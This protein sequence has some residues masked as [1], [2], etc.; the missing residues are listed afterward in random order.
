MKVKESINQNNKP[1]QM[2]KLLALLTV[3]I[4]TVIGVYGQAPGIFNYQGVARNSV[5]NVLVNK[6]ITLRLTIHDVAS[7]GAVVYQE[8]RAVT[9]NPFGLFNVQVGSAGATNVTGTIAG[10][11]WAVG[12]KYIQVEIDP[13]GGTTF[14][15]IG[16]AQIASVPYAWYAAQAGDLILPYN[17]TQADNGTLFKITNSGTNTGS[18]ALEGLTNSTA[19]NANA[20]IGTVSSTSPGG[21]SAGIR[22]INNGTGGLGIGVYGSQAGSGWG[23]YGTTPSG[24]GVYGNTNSGTGVYGFANTGTGVFGTSTT[25]NAGSFSNT[26]AA[27]N[28]STLLVTSNGT[29]WAGDFASTNATTRALRTA[30]GLQH[31]GIGEA[32]NR[33]LVSDA[34]GNATW[35]DAS[36]I[37]VVTGSG[38]LNFV[39]KW[40][41]TGT[42]LGNSQIFDNGTSVGIN[43]A[44]PNAAYR[45]E[46]NGIQRINLTNTQEGGELRFQEGTLFGAPNHW[47]IDNFESFAGGNKFR[48]WNDA[49]SM[50]FQMMPTG[51]VAVGNMVFSDQPQSTM[52]IEG[53]LAVGAT[54]SG[55]NA[56]PTNGM[57]VEGNVGIGTAV[58]TAKLHLV[59][60]NAAVQNSFVVSQSNATNTAVA[61]SISDVN[62]TST[63][64]GNGAIYS[65]RGTGSLANT[66]LYT[67][68]ATSITGVA[69]SIQGFGVQGTSESGYGVTGL[70]TTGIGVHGINLNTGNAARFE[71]AINA[72]NASPVVLVNDVS[73]VASSFGVHSTIAS[74]APGGFSAALRG[75][76]NGTGG[77]GIGVW[78]SQNGLGWGVYGTAAGA[79]LGVVGVAGTNGTGVYALANGPASSALHAINDVGFAG[80]F[81]ATGTVNNN[82]AL[83]VSDADI[84]SGA[85]VYRKAGIYAEL[86]PLATGV[87]RYASPAAIL[88]TSV[89]STTVALASG[90][91]VMGASSSGV[92][93]MGNTNGGVGLVGITWANGY[94]LQAY[95]NSSFNSFGSGGT[96][97]QVNSNSFVG[98]PQI[99]LNE[100][101]DDFARLT[102]RNTNALN[103][104]NNFWDIAG[105]T[106]NTRSFE[107]LNF[108]NNATGNLMS[109]TGTGSVGIGTTNPDATLFVNEGKSALTAGYGFGSTIAAKASVSAATGNNTIALNTYTN[110]ST[111]QNVSIYSELGTTGTFNYGVRAD[112]VN[113][114]VGGTSW[115][116]FS[117][118]FINSA[119]TRAG[120]FFGNV[121]VVGTL[122]KSAGT[123]KIDHPQDPANKYLIHSFVESP[124]MMNVY[125]GNIVTDA[126]GKAVVTLPSYF[127][128]ENMDF[129]YQLTVV[130]ETQFAMARVSR[131]ISNNQFEVMTDKPGIEISWQVT[132]VRNDAY[133]RE[134]RIVPEV[135]KAAADKGKYLHPELFGASAQQKIGPAMTP[136][137]T[138]NNLAGDPSAKQ[139]VSNNRATQPDRNLPSVT[140]TENQLKAEKT[141]N[142]NAG[143]VVKGEPAEMPKEKTA[144]VP[145]P[146][147][148]EKGTDKEK[149]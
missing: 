112:L 2:K 3:L 95:G 51:R 110:G 75:Q 61:V 19:G 15:N 108:Y 79:G 31:T 131:K 13:N 119:N 16:T 114:P 134:H 26:N 105:Y 54:Y 115:G 10:V 70:S 12:A 42:N 20:I 23:V 144:E 35:K 52:D 128:A 91:G 97:V 99:L 57:I 125:N 103:S 96:T 140:L 37:G 40:T 29:G 78:G 41:P 143:Q 63:A 132:G 90:T 55:T 89:P 146:V 6:A 59:N 33:I 53:N 102:L 127:Q 18:T 120:V 139:S 117:W 62:T 74:T 73:T 118:D 121:D 104:G 93:V 4:V 101:A 44:T 136:S 22:G 47:I 130:D 5:G 141:A 49:G 81:E 85:S 87:T 27:N 64:Y 30:G 68:I 107:R 39:P 137:V 98:G 123:F 126:S 32:N 34:V 7:G 24:L 92:G 86:T 124:D 28:S 138:S 76:N 9:T 94:A 133:A 129:K 122:S 142:A 106:N 69:A 145:V 17:K 71:N 56:A 72:A 149:Q 83:Y 66:Y 109:I 48:I 80:L 46:V 36:A 135:D 14:I 65:Q 67:G 82:A 50:I 1:K 8:N 38:T 147:K 100:Q 45:L 11:N 21:F 84:T 43:T 116:M 111:S 88:G 60:T 58:P 148:I 25:G 77:L 113:A